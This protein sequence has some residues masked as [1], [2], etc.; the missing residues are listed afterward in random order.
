LKTEGDYINKENA[1]SESTWHNEEETKYVE[2]S[3][4]KIK[5]WVEAIYCS[6]CGKKIKKLEE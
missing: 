5:H 3:C 1:M 2:C 4:G 6:K